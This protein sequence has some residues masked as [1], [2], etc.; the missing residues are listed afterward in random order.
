M[1]ST[2]TTTTQT[3]QNSKNQIFLGTQSEGISPKGNPAVSVEPL[4][5]RWE[6]LQTLGKPLEKTKNKKKTQK[7]TTKQTKKK[8]KKTKKKQKKH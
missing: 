2:Q 8:P 3:S 1:I 5:W 6:T 4:V 7:K